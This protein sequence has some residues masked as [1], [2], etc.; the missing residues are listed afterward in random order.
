MDHS[1]VDCIVRFHDVGRLYELDRCIFSLVGQSYRPL[2]IILAL[3]RFS[4]AAVAATR[5]RLAPMLDLPGAPTMEVHNLEQPVPKDAR[6]LLLNMGIRAAQGRYVGFLDYDDL[7]YPEAYKTLVSQLRATDFAIAF[8]SVRV[9]S[10]DVYGQFIRINSELKDP[11]FSGRGLIDLFR[12]NFC[13][14]HSYLLDRH[15]IDSD[16]LVFD[17][18]LAWEEDYDFLLRI[19]AKYSSDFSLIKTQI[20]EYYFKT[21]GSNSTG[22]V[23]SETKRSAYD[24]VS[25]MIEARRCSTIVSSKVQQENGISP[26]QPR[27]TIRDFIDRQVGS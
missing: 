22:A 25:A 6:T 1:Q 4:D 8:A 26:P 17:S 12:A 16:D 3:Q 9:V 14:L 21:D 2:N 7:L 24:M 20:G 13:P 19:C 27:M 15:R 10:A 18:A 11:P 5:Q 23:L